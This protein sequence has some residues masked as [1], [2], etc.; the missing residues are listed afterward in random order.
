MS[1]VWTP[2]WALVPP[3]PVLWH[4]SFEFCTWPNLRS[5]EFFGDIPEG[6]PVMNRFL[7][8]HPTLEELV[9]MTGALV[10]LPP[11]FLPNLRILRTCPW[12]IFQILGATPSFVLHTVE[13][14]FR[15]F[16]HPRIDLL[17]SALGGRP[18]LRHLI[19]TRPL[20]ESQLRWFFDAAPTLETF[21]GFEYTGDLELLCAS[22]YL[23]TPTSNAK[24]FD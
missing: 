13:I 11:N 7:T 20:P 24:L 14:T 2:E 17:A 16:D 22:V 12:N 8:Q 21:N 19:Y 9:Y 1:R 10:D 23:L 6:D 18:S 5:L 3:A 4:G 15:P